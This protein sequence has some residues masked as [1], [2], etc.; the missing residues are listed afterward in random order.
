MLFRSRRVLFR[1]RGRRRASSGTTPS[2]QCQELPDPPSTSLHPHLTARHSL[3]GAEQIQMGCWMKP[4]AKATVYDT[5][6]RHHL[7]RARTPTN[8]TRRAS[9]AVYHQHRAWT[10]P[11][12]RI[13]CTFYLAYFPS[14]PACPSKHYVV[15]VLLPPQSHSLGRYHGHIQ[16]FLLAPPSSTAPPAT[17]TYLF[18]L[19]ASSRRVIIVVYAVQSIV[20]VA[21]ETFGQYVSVRSWVD[22]GD[23]SD[24][25]AGS[26]RDLRHIRYH[27]KRPPRSRL[28]HSVPF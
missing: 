21:R 24:W 14:R 3:R 15:N 22:K 19:I 26:G 6:Q 28:H 9:A 17:N 13:I 12:L 10:S 23:D 25:R 4:T 27:G 18:L 7:H 16:L 1:S 8:C 11:D 5:P 20:C 2:N